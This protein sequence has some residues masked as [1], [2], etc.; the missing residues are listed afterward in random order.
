[1]GSIP[2][3]SLRGPV[4]GFPSFLVVV[5]FFSAID[6]VTPNFSFDYV[7]KKLHTLLTNKLIYKEINANEFVEF[8]HCVILKVMV[9][10]SFKLVVY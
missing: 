5:V 4:L 8:Q 3:F 1:M 6:Y 2:L 10:L 9:S 7:L